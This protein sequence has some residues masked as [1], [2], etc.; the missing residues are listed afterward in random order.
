MTTSP[1]HHISVLA[2]QVVSHLVQRPGGT[3]L[4]GTAGGAGHSAALLEAAGPSARLLALDRDPTAIAVATERLE[5]FGSRATVRRG[6]FGD[7]ATLAADHAP[8]T[9]I[10]LD[11]GVSSPQLDTPARGFSFQADGPLDMRMDPDHGESAAELI[12]RLTEAELISILRE[13]GEEPRAR[14]IARAIIGARPWSSTTELA[15]CVA[16]ASGYK[17]SRTHPATRTFQALRI[18]VNDELGQLRRGLDAA[19]DLLEPGGRLAV[20]SFHSLEDRI[21]KRRLRTLAG[22]GTPRDAYGHPAIP[23]LLT[24]VTRKPIRGAVVEPDNPRSRSASLR[25]A[26]RLPA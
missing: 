11:I 2:D 14:R 16:R 17:N 25:V 13:F 6:T 20:I 8:F 21:V 3:F 23:P 22:I 9:G 26:T 12:D 15:E 5:R 1:F 10:L 7:M 4:D 18:A 24:L 19:V